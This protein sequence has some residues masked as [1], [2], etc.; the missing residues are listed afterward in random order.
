MTPRATIGCDPEFFLQDLKTGKLVSSVGKIPGTKQKP[1]PIEGGAGLQHD[2]VAVEFSSPVGKNGEDFVRKLRVVLQN[3]GRHMPP[4]TKLVALPS[5][6]FPPEELLTEEAKQFG[7][8]PDYNAWKLEINTVSPHPDPTFRSCGGH[9]HVGRV[10]GDGN[11]FLLNPYGKVDMIKVMDAIHGLLSI[12][13]DNSP[14]AANRRSLYGKAGCHRPTSYGVEY[15]VLSNFW[16]KSPRL[17]LLMDSL[18]QD[19]LSLI[20]KGE[21]QGL[22]NAI[23]EERIQDIIN[24]NRVDD[25]KKAFD[26]I[27]TILSDKSKELLAEC[28]QNVNKWEMDNE[29]RMK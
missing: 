4:G 1:F 13:M 9:I 25:A 3:I 2:N 10:E 11:D 27:N 26:T 17:V 12:L 20:R 29:W 16:L 19:A 22:L 14:A 24:N 15:R 28:L 7:C 6:C 21:H 8:D 5:A 23:G 18:T